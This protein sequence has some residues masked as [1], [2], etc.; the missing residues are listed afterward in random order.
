LLR[1]FLDAHD[2]GIVLAPDGALRLASG[3][4][5]IPDVCWERFPNRELPAEPVPDLA[6]EC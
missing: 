4:V 6:V 5:R 3:L 2:L 1:N